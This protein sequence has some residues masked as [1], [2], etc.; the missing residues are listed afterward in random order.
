VAARALETSDEEGALRQALA[1]LDRASQLT[2]DDPAVGE[3]RALVLARLANRTGSKADGAASL[4]AYEKLVVTDP[5]N[6]R[7]WRGLALAR[8]IGTDSSGAEAALARAD[9]LENRSR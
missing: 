3:E 8:R 4:A 7:A 5:R 1:V 2:P 6:P 9:F